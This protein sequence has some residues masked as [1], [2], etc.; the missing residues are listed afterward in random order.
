MAT[1]N[2]NL[3]AA[4]A[5]YALRLVELSASPKPDYSLDGKSVSWTT[6]QRF[7]LDSMDRIREQIRAEDGITEVV[8]RGVS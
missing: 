4:L 6:Y 3:T 5:N 1:M 8:T 2:E 7:I